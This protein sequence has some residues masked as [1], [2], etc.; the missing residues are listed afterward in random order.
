MQIDQEKKKLV[1]EQ[2]L[3]KYSES[4]NGY[5]PKENRMFVRDGILTVKAKSKFT[6]NV[7][8]FT[9]MIYFCVKKK[10][11]VIFFKQCT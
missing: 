4:I 11:P 10:Q 2:A 3:K 5:V 9:D 1:K 7:V 6:A 8:L